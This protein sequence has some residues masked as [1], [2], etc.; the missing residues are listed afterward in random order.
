MKIILVNKTN[1]IFKKQGKEIE[2]KILIEV[3]LKRKFFIEK[4]WLIL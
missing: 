4:K 1:K 2:I 3:I